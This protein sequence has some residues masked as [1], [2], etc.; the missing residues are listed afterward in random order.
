MIDF[1]KKDLSRELYERKTLVKIWEGR[2][3]LHIVPANQVA[4]Y[5]QVT[6]EVKEKLAVSELE[7]SP[8]QILKALDEAGALMHRN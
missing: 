7:A 6:K 5:Y 4:E 2:A 3:T 1:H 8:Q